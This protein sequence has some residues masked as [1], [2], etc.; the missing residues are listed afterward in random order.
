MFR[1]VIFLSIA[2][3]SI[4]ATPVYGMIISDV[5]SFIA[6]TTDFI[7]NIE[8]FEDGAIG[9]RTAPD[10]RSFDGFTMAYSGARAWGITNR[11]D[12]RVSGIYPTDGQR[13]LR[14]A[15]NAGNNDTI[16]FTF[17]N[18][19][20]TFAVDIVDLES[21]G[22]LEF[23]TDTGE[24]GMAA[25]NAGNGSRNFFGFI[26]TTPFTSLTLSSGSNNQRTPDGIALDHIRFSSSVATV[27][28]PMTGALA[29]FAG[30]ALLLSRRNAR[31]LRDR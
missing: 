8:S 23:S 9:L 5:T 21:G 19:T 3:V 29:M 31:W 16:T 17:D 22:P 12:R 14:I 4:H 10:T 7:F 24:T 26:S 6:S 15:F 1:T 13:S 20:T 11:N 27:P 18:P 30:G 28:E 2:L 25:T